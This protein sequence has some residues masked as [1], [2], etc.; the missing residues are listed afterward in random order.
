MSVLKCNKCDIQTM[1]TDYLKDAECLHKIT[2][3][4]IV[5]A[6][7]NHMKMIQND[8]ATSQALCEEFMTGRQNT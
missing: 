7:R 3:K 4:E 1:C 8:F 2:K 5:H 6:M